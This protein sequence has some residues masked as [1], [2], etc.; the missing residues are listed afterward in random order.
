MEELNKEFEQIVKTHSIKPDDSLYLGTALAGE[1]GEVCN[2]IKKIDIR[3]ELVAKGETIVSMA[4]LES[5]IDNL[6][7]ELGDVLFYLT[8]LANKFDLTL[9][10]LMTSQIRK[11][12]VLDDMKEGVFLK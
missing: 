8:A 1:T 5:Y 6:K 10:D 12:T 2:A 3:Q 7:E 11:L 9:N 4:T